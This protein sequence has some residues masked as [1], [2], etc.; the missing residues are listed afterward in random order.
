MSF[1]HDMER[2]MR[3]IKSDVSK[4]VERVWAIEYNGKTIEVHNQMLHETLKVDGL[5]IDE[6]TRKSIWS[7]IMPYSTLKGIFQGVDGKQHRLY[8]KL[9]GF[10]KLNMIIKVDGKKIF[11]DTMAFVMNPW[12]N[13]EPIAAYIEAQ[14]KAGHIGDELPDDVLLYDEHHP[15]MAPGEAD[16]MDAEHVLPGY[17]KKLVKLFLEQANNPSNKTRKVTYEKILDEKVVNYFEELIEELTETEFDEA[18]I[19]Q[20]A[21]W[22]LEHATHREAVKFAIALL[23]F[24]KCEPYKERLETIAKHEEFTGVVLF[25]LRNG[26]GYSNDFVLQLAKEL[27]G[28]GKVAA[29]D[30]LEANNNDVKHWLLTEGYKTAVAKQYIAMHC[31]E[32]GKL[33]IA[34]HEKEISQQLYDGANDL[35]QILLED[36]SYDRL[37]MF[38]YTGQVLMRFTHHAKTHASRL[39]HISTLGQIVVYMDRD[40]E[41]WEEL[42]E[43][44][45]KPHERNAVNA[46]IEAIKAEGRGKEEA[47]TILQSGVEDDEAALEVALF[48]KLD[49]AE[50]I[51]EKL[52]QKPVTSFYYGIIMAY[53]DTKQIERLSEFALQQFDIGALKDLEKHCI[54]MIISNL[55][56]L[57]GV[58]KRLLTE[59]LLSEDA[60]LQYHALLS[61]EDWSKESWSDEALV[62]AV[63][64]VSRL[65][66][67]RELRK[68]AKDL[69]ENQ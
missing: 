55:Y 39:S 53:E 50:I 16:Q 59:C 67:V 61:L 11:H 10:V 19:Q 23:G 42:Y 63:T 47:L 6:N 36:F 57:E 15:R 60:E 56:D 5:L 25:A 9:G 32:K 44:S 46:S 52:N 68:F 12:D 18:K 48:Y 51:F 8:V 45:W 3:N 40:E 17:T 69:L 43:M 26:A 21:L 30:F 37:E 65:S 33:D 28:W 41:A 49:V 66:E 38:E 22:L 34:L 14:A 24:T 62:A 4:A 7:H 35:I 29:I 20:E 64:H 1:K 27:N 2:E 54:R 13:K 31:V 58:G